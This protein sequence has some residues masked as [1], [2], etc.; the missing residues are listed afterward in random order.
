[1]TA[2]EVRQQSKSLDTFKLKEEIYTR[3]QQMIADASNTE[4]LEEAVDDLKQRLS[5]HAVNGS[6]REKELK[7]LT[8]KVRDL[9]KKVESC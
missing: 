1:M 5:A 9:E 2:K 8:S 4:A 7:Q 6:Q 3:V